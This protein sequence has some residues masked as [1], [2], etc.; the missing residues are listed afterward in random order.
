MLGLTVFP[1]DFEFS[2]KED[3][4]LI[5]NLTLNRVVNHPNQRIRLVVRGF[6]VNPV[7]GY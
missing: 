1:S 6:E 2:L 5:K 3:L 4:R 7:C